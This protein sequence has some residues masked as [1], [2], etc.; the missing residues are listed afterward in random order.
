M[1]EPLKPRQKPGPPKDPNAKKT[2]SC[3][4]RP[5]TLRR[6]RAEMP[7]GTRQETI[8]SLI[9]GYLDHA[10]YLRNAEHLRGKTAMNDDPEI[11]AAISLPAIRDVLKRLGQLSLQA[12]ASGDSLAFTNRL[13]VPLVEK[14]LDDPQTMTQD[15]LKDFTACLLASFVGRETE[16]RPCTTPPNN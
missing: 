8:E 11:I 16:E 13:F 9:L 10:E 2:F 3:R 1:Q 14:F 6:I 5:A 7:E 4:F 15:E 12:Q